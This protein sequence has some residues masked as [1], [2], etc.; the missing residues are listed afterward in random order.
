MKVQRILM[1]AL[2]LQLFTLPGFSQSV[3]VVS[4]DPAILKGETRIG[5]LYNY[6]GMTIGKLAE[7]EY[8]TKKTNEYNQKKPGSGDSWSEKWKSDRETRYQPKFEDLL[9]KYLK[10][11]GVS[12]SPDIKDSKYSIILKTTFIEPGYNIYVSSQPAYINVEIYI[13]ETTN[14]SNILVK[15]TMKKIPGRS[16][17]GEDYDTGGRIEEAYAK[18]GKNLGSFLQKKALK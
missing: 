1:L 14:P 5:L 18:C 10:E 2:F 6:D 4:G 11:V 9:N 15:M 13:V 17:M 12:A 16:A 3:V 8:V 7:E